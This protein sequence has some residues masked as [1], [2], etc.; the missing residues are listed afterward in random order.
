MAYLYSQEDPFV[1][2]TIF[3]KV[4]SGLWRIFPRRCPVYGVLYCTIEAWSTECPVS[5]VMSS[6]GGVRFMVFFIAQ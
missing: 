2:H 4:K 1:G 5:G 6:P 3:P